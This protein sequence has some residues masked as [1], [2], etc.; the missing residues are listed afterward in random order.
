MKELFVVPNGEKED[1]MKVELL[2]GCSAVGCKSKKS[3]VIVLITTNKR[4]LAGS[5]NLTEDK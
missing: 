4:V 3:K 5:L 1:V 2:E